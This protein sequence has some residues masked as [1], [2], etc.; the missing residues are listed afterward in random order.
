MIFIGDGS[1]LWRAVHH[2]RDAGF[3][4]DLVCTG[5][6]TP[7]PPAE[8]VPVRLV[9]RAD[10]PGA[11]LRALATDGVVWSI[12]NPFILDAPL[13]R[14]GLRV[15]NIHGG[16]LPAYR[17]IPMATVAYAILNGETEFAATLHEVD[18]R[19]DTGPVLAER[20]FPIGPDDVFEDVMVELVEACHQLFVEHLE[21]AVAG[22]LTG[23][24]QPAEPS[25]Y[26]GAAAMRGLS[27]H[28]DHPRYARATDLGLF[29][30]FYP[31]LAEAWS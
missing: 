2:A 22:T 23:R 6:R 16:P 19:I 1:L 13:L 4:V 11:E 10:V 15:Y 3:A 25:G 7:V 30:D 14:S 5:G 31:D 18:E 8:Q 12:D 9:T 27:A 17:G 28:R 29:E 20:R 24:P 21:A 26:Y